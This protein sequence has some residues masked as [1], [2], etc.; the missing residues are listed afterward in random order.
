MTTNTANRSGF[1]VRVRFESHSHG[2]LRGTDD[3]LKTGLG[4]SVNMNL[5]INRWFEHDS[6]DTF[7][8]VP[9]RD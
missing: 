5:G 2:V 8:E 9:F 3:D 6:C 7:K 4:I 1:K